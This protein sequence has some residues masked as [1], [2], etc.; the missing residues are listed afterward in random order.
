LALT[1]A[2][3]ELLKNLEPAMQAVDA[4]LDLVGRTSNAAAGSGSSVIVSSSTDSQAARVEIAP[5]RFLPRIEGVY[6][7]DA[8]REFRTTVMRSD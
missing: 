8:S 1:A 4:A 7:F 6:R 5:S 2:G 3:S